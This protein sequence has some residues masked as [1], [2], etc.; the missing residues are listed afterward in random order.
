MKYIP[1]ENTAAH[2]WRA[3]CLADLAAPLCRCGRPKQ[4]GFSLCRR[5]FW[6]LPKKLRR[7]LYARIGEGYEAAYRDAGEYL[8]QNKE[9][10]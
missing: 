7:S 8:D 9:T 2:R 3:T 1:D 5:C 10:L 6:R 4:R